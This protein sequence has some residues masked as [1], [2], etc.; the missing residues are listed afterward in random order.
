[1]NR[2]YGFYVFTMMGL[3]ALVLSL[4][5]EQQVA[6]VSRVNQYECR[7]SM[8][9]G[10]P[11]YQPADVR[12]LIHCAADRWPVDISTAMYVADRE[13]NFQP[14]AY[15]PSGASGVYQHMA[16]LWP[17]RIA[18]F[19]RNTGRRFDVR[20]TSPF[21]ARAN[22]LVTIRMVHQGGWGPWQ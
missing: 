22:V 11:G 17:A 21:N 19:L 6:A 2:T 15:N 3:V 14:H 18:S 4:Q 5:P 7:L 20:H 13:S 10:R 8:S 9:N 12:R 16:H 1:M